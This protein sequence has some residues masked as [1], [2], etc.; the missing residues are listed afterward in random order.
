MGQQL[1]LNIKPISRAEWLSKEKITDTIILNARGV[2]CRSKISDTTR[3]QPMNRKY[4]DTPFSGLNFLIRALM[5][6]QII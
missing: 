3:E 2:P 5:A 1:I 6:D 4:G